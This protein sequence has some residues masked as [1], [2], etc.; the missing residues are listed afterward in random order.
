MWSSSGASAPSAPTNRWCE[1]QR[2][3]PFWKFEHC[4]RSPVHLPRAAVLFLE[5][6]NRWLHCASDSRRKLSLCSFRLGHGSNHLRRV[7]RIVE[8]GEVR[9]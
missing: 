3:C 6:K 1:G 9:S 2:F 5:A 8:C 7:L 4:V